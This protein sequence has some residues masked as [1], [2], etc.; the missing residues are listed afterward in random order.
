MKRFFPKTLFVILVVLNLTSFSQN[1][2]VITD[3]SSYNA[4]NSAVL[5]VYSTSKGM[6]VP[7]MTSAQVLS[8][9]N[10]ATGLLVFNTTVN[11]FWFY[12]GSLWDDLSSGTNSLWSV[13]PSTGDVYL[14][15]FNSNIGIG[16][17]E[18]MGKLSIVG[19][20]GSNPD[21]PLFEIKDEFGFPI[22]SVSSEGVRVYVKDVSKGTT[23]GFAVGRYGI[24]KGVPDTSYL[25]VTPDSTRVYMQQGNKGSAGG[26]AVG[27][28]GIAKGHA[29]TIFYASN[30]STRVYT[31]TN[32]KGVSGGFAVGRYG[33]AKGATE[34]YLHMTKDNYL[35]GHRAGDSLEGGMYNTF[36]GFESGINTTTGGHNVFMG[37]QSGYENTTGQSNVFMGN[38][39]G[40]SNTGG[41]NNIFIGFQ[42][43]Y[44]NTGDVLNGL[45]NVFIG[46]YA[47]SWNETGNNN[48]F[49]GEESGKWNST[50]SNNVYVG[51]S[52]Y[53]IAGGT[54]GVAVGYNSRATGSNSVSLGAY[55]GY[56][57]TGSD[58]VYLGY[59]AGYGNTLNDALIIEN[60]WPA[61]NPFIIGNFATDVLRIN[62]TLGVG[63]APGYKFDVYA[64]AAASYAARFFNDGN[65]ENR[66]GII[67]QAGADI[68]S[69]T[70]SGWYINFRD[71]DGSS[72]GWISSN[73]GVMTYG[74]KS[75][76]ANKPGL[77]LSKQNAA[78]LLNKIQI[79]DY[80]TSVE[81][82]VLQTGFFNSN[83]LDVFPQSLNFNAE[84]NQ[85]FTNYSTFIP[86]LIK[87][88]QEQENRISSLEK[89]NAELKLKIDEILKKL[90]P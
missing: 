75:A 3:N 78:D 61:T 86:V 62:A 28:Y 57:S 74:T 54:N 22:F 18:P 69:S 21:D 52:S 25:I 29:N 19:N 41:L 59:Q 51:R 2:T 84:E 73:N 47:G 31:D 50:G 11:S 79:Y 71:G 83:L 4:D 66:Y 88:H 32:G 43:G 6:L 23:G 87:A 10:P 68:G 14:D 55:A 56:N 63:T 60:E 24:A 58:C 67:I 39:A 35:I 38:Q 13:N 9:S 17:N 26:F 81:S 64:D 36:L 37:Y 1:N 15:N 70:G 46:T 44:A 20:T 85:Y 53:G 34:N 16:T 89:E 7:R 27:R 8:I 80:Y 42:S 72:V 45:S 76:D 90:N 77:T 30:D 48:I 12:N 49:L 40:F 82:K 33:I 65:N 5:D